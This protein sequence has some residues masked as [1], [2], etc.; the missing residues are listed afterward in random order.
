MAQRNIQIPVAA[1]AV[2]CDQNHILKLSLFGS[3]L[4]DDFHA[5]SDIDMLV[6]FDPAARIT[7]FDKGRIC[8]E[9]SALIDRDVDLRTKM[10]LS[11]YFRDRVISEAENIYVRR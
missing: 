1:L 11:P 6:E 10:E 7:Y 9:L 4:R 8:E 3:V 5:G 2:Y